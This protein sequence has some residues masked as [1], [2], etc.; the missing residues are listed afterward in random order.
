MVKKYNIKVNGKS[1]EVEVEELGSSTTNQTDQ[2]V[3]SQSDSQSTTQSTSLI[4]KKESAPK[5]ENE[6]KKEESNH[7]TSIIEAPMSGLVIDVKVKKG[8]SVSPGAKLL[9][10]E[11]MKMENDI[12]SDIGGIIESIHC[13]KGDNVETGETLITIA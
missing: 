4:E 12:V 9:V 2:P 7:S 11:A 1:Y 10:L 3:H 8:D 13:K 5:S 6:T